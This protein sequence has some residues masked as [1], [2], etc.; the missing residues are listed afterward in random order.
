MDGA[1]K[2]CDRLCNRSTSHSN[3]SATTRR[4]ICWTVATMAERWRYGYPTRRLA[5][6]HACVCACNRRNRWTRLAHCRFIS[7]HNYRWN[8]AVCPCRG[9]LRGIDRGLRSCCRFA[10]SVAFWATGF[11]GFHQDWTSYF[12]RY[13]SRHARMAWSS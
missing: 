12:L 11:E 4:N 7:Q 10:R 5:C 1:D 2:I 9:K 8:R 13:S 6:Q 3:C